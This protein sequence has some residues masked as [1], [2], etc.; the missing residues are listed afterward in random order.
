MITLSSTHIV[1]KFTLYVNARQV[2]QSLGSNGHR[3]EAATE[4]LKSLGDGE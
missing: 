1:G 4:V 3:V 2:S